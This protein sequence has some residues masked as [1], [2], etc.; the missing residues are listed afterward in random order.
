MLVHVHPVGEGVFDV[1]VADSEPVRVSQRL[2][3][4][5][6]T[7]WFWQEQ[8]AVVLAN[9]DG[10]AG[11]T[12]TVGLRGQQVPVRVEDSRKAVLAALGIEAPRGP[13]GPLVVRS[14]MPG[15]VV[16]IL[17]KPAER[18]AE[19]QPLLVVEAMKMENEMRAP[20]AATVSS[21]SVGEGAAVEAGAPLVVLE[22]LANG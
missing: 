13:Q 6:S 19:G 18:V 15:R 3:A 7:Q 2:N 5:G 11:S 9:V 12:L 20:R 14:P 16:K 4:R 10:G 17:V 21:L 8:N 1:Q 22:P